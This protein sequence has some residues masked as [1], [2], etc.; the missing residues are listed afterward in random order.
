MRCGQTDEKAEQEWDGLPVVVFLGGMIYSFHP[1][2]IL[3]FTAA[4]EK[5]KRQYEV[6]Y[7]GKILTQ[8]SFLPQ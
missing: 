6:D 8:Q 4:M 7:C 3:Q 2:V 5:T 1:Y